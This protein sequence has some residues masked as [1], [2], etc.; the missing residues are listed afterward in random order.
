M[1]E[2]DT[3]DREV[4]ARRRVEE[5]GE[6]DVDDLEERLVA[7]GEIAATIWK[8]CWTCWTL[9]GISI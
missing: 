2:A 8:S 5:T 1:A 6:G 3:T 9:T 7:E 4:E